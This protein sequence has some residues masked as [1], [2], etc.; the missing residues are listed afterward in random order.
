MS[1]ISISNRTP[2]TYLIGWSHLN[3]WYY[4]RR[5][6][7]NC[8][9][10]DLWT[11]YFTSSDHVKAFRQIHGEP[12][13]IEIRRVFDN[14]KKCASWETRLLKKINAKASTL[15]L[16]ESN[17]DKNWDTTGLIG[18]C[19]AKNAETGEKLGKILLT[20]SR[21]KSGEIIAT[22]KNR[23]QS[24]E[25][26]AKRSRIMTGRS[27]HRKGK[28]GNPCSLETKE[29]LKKINEGK[30]MSEATSKKISISLTGLVRSPEQREN[31]KGPKNPT[32][33][34][35]SKNTCMQLSARA[36]VNELKHLANKLNVTL[37]KG[38]TRRSD[39]WISTKLAE[40]RKFS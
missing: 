9:P 7:K 40:L 26:R 2:Y 37:G 17:G 33:I 34:D 35:K 5:T 6:A 32:A 19:A 20:D 13:V 30:I 27:S 29:K 24:A 12:D 10:S 22:S 36:S 39:E 14:V 28:K 3:K 11:K 31:Y 25:E 16:N 21:W 4:G 23:K 1:N 38:W 8:H 15:F 18:Y